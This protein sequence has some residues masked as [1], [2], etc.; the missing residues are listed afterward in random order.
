MV[1][2]MHANLMPLKAGRQLLLRRRIRQWLPVWAVVFLTTA[3]VCGWQYGQLFKANRK[4]AQLEL[5]EIPSRQR[6]EAVSQIRLR[7]DQFHQRQSLL[8]TLNST[9]HPLQ[10]VGIIGDGAAQTG[11]AL[12]INSFKLSTVKQRGPLAN[13]AGTTVDVTEHMELDLLGFAID[14]LTVAAFVATVEESGVFDRVVLES[15]EAVSTDDGSRTFKLT[16]QYH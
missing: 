13:A 4:L 8:K 5:Q 12:R 6:V 15:S 3:M 10:L 14:D 9:G 1:T 11:G 7:L 2:V 16:C